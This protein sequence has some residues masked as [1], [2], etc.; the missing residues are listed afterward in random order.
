[1][2][3]DL[4]IFFPI[5][6]QTWPREIDAVYPTHIFLSGTFNQSILF[7]NL[8]TEEQITTI[9]NQFQSGKAAGPD[10]S[11]VYYKAVYKLHFISA[12]AH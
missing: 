9:A 10:I 7:L 1:M 8:T 12:R 2:Q 4:S 3:T 11:Q 6:G 5:S